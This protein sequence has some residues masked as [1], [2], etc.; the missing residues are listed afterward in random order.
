MSSFSRVGLSLPIDG[1][2]DHCIKIQ[3]GEHIP[4]PTINLQVEMNKSEEKERDFFN[5]KISEPKFN[6][7]QG[8][9]QKKIISPEAQR[10]RD[11][12]FSD[13][14]DSSIDDLAWERFEDWY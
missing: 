1:S 6:P 2:K 8:N 5:I 13:P 7:F 10:A 9:K 11:K 4:F 3:A 14:P 12:V